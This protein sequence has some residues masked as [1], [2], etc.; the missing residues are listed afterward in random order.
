[1]PAPLQLTL[2]VLCKHFYPPSGESEAGRQRVKFDSA[3]YPKPDTH[4]LFPIKVKTEF[5]QQYMSGKQH[6]ERTLKDQLLH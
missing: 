2:H 3:W 1:M 5:G 4:S 6:P